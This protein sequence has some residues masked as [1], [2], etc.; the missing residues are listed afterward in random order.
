MTASAPATPAGTGTSTYSGSPFTGVKMWANDYYRTE[1]YD[2]AIPEL[3]A[4]MAEKA[5]KV[6][7]VPSFMWL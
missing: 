4:A 6:A 7:E 5:K 1:V 3:S 2:L